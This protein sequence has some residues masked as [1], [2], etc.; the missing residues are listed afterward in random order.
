MTLDKTFLKEKI[1]PILITSILSALIA[2][3]QN[4]LVAYTTQIPSGT[5]EALSGGVGAVLSAF[6]YLK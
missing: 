4:V 6:K 5:S 2:M 3:L 1:L